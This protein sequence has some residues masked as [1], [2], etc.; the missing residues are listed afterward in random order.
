MPPPLPDHDTISVQHATQGAVDSTFQVCALSLSRRFFHISQ[1][2]RPSSL[3]LFH[4]VITAT[5]EIEHP[6]MSRETLRQPQVVT[7]ELIQ[8]H[9]LKA[10]HL[11]SS[12]LPPAKLDIASAISRSASSIPRN[13]TRVVVSSDLD[14]VTRADKARGGSRPEIGV[15]L[16]HPSLWNLNRLGNR[17]GARAPAWIAWKCLRAKGCWCS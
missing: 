11:S 5:A 17:C 2:P 14:A 6:I 13:S 4:H 16:E 10:E 15:A 1:N 12:S 9:N 8:P 7:Y 3:T